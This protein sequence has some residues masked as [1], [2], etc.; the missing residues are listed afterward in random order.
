MSD[1]GFQI[2]GRVIDLSE[3]KT[4]R[5]YTSQIVVLEEDGR[6]QR[7]YPISFADKSGG[8]VK[9]LARVKLNDV[10]KVHF[11]LR[12]RKPDQRWFVDLDGW[13][14]EIL[15]SD[16]DAER[17]QPATRRDGPPPP[18]DDDAPPWGA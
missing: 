17:S 12:S 16:S 2:T 4:D 15:S 13:K 1:Q 14:V 6:Y 7:Q 3:V 8:A 18:S 9:K 10:I 11:D 5:G